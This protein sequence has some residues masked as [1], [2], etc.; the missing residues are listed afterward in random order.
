LIA[1]D[2]EQGISDAIV[3]AAGPL[4]LQGNGTKAMMLR[5]VQAADTLSTRSLSGITLYA[6]NEL[7]MSAKAGTRL[8]DIE[9]AL[10]ERGQQMIGEPPH[11]HGENQTIGGIFATN[12]SGPRR[13]T[14]GAMR[15]HVLGVRC[16]NG[17]GEIQRFGGR[18]LKNVTGL[19]LA[20]FLTGSF[21]TLAVLTE[22]TFK[23]LPVAEAVGT[24]AIRNVEADAAVKILSAGLG[25]P[26]SVSGA[27]YVPAEKTAYLRIEDFAVSVKYRT[28][29]LAAQLRE[30]GEAEILDTQASKVLWRG[31]RDCGPLPMGEA[32]WRISA[33]PSA[34]P[35]ILR[36]LEAFGI[37]GFLDWGGGLVWLSG[38]ATQAAHE[39][40]RAAAV[41]HGGVWWLMD[42]PAPLRAA[43]DVVPAE[44]PA[45]AAISAR[46]RHD[47]DPRGLFNP[48]RL[49]AA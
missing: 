21:G 26:F 32:S 11:I 16:V 42:A 20:K 5:P 22:V 37:A 46:V 9:T 30:Y 41:A 12:L 38:P 27:A 25:S 13:V 29:K 40:V 23:V 7:V 10:A 33:A 19:D 1:P 47:F 34:G 6:P 48:G 49:R 36:A 3:A 14:G 24:L 2:T 45:L 15:D 31:I 4:L 17:R 44:A 35:K 28:E 39:A 18:V 43:V 8:A